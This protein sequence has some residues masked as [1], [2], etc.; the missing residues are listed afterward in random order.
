MD[1]GLEFGPL[2]WDSCGSCCVQSID[3]NMANLCPWTTHE[4][5]ICVSMEF[6]PVTFDLGALT[7]TMGF[8]WKL[9]S[10]QGIY[11]NKANLCLWTTHK[12]WICMDVEFW[13]CDV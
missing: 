5:W 6:G 2:R 11:A 12:G 3:A 1:M 7:L 13:S 8:L 4:G 10:V 9:S